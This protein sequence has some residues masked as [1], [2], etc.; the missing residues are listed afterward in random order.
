MKAKELIESAKCV[1]CNKKIGETGLPLFWRI[2]T[3]RHGIDMKAVK[4][5]DG[6]AAFLG[7]SVQLADAMGTNEDLTQVLDETK[8]FTVCEPCSQGNICIMTL[9][10]GE[11]GEYG[12][13]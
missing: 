4:R 5:Y 9:A 8:T 2:T 12:E 10:L 11:E 6:L 3:E 13:E 7:G 1:V